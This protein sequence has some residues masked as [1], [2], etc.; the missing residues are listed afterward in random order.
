MNIQKAA[1]KLQELQKSIGEVI[2]GQD[3]A[4]ETILVGLLAEGHV[5]IEGLP[6]LAKTSIANTLAKL[7]DCPFKRIQFTPDLLPG[8]LI[9]TT[10]YI[11]QDHSFRISKGPIFTHVLLA[12]EINRAPA[13]VQSALLEAMQEKQ[14]TIGGESFPL[15]TPFFVIATQNPIE[16]QGTYPLPEAQIDRFMLKVSIDYPNEDAEKTMLK[17]KLENQKG[18]V[19]PILN[20][21]EIAALQNASK[22]IYADE[23]ILEYTI[24]LA[25]ATRM[26]SKLLQFGASSRAC[27]H[28]V[29]SAKALALIRGRA[30]VTPDDIKEISYSVLKHR[31]RLTF[32]AEAEEK[33]P[34]DILKDLLCHLPVP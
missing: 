17:E 27:L 28:L 5:L 31:L 11:P 14:V 24:N 13:K 7:L 34:E 21:E 9:G 8:D 4:I 15:P 19:K 12:D 10:M 2:F 23:K 33:K 1:S 6:G 25:K 3:T 26:P 30:F 22:T 20:P 29:Q 18:T 32:E 16:H